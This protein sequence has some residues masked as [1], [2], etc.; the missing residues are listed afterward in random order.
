MGTMEKKALIAQR[1]ISK[2][3][4]EITDG[5][6]VLWRYGKHFKITDFKEIHHFKLLIHFLLLL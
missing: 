6:P 5:M 3:N 4:S 2:D 1:E